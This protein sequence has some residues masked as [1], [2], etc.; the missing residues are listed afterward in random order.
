[1]T[2]LFLFFFL[3]HFFVVRALVDWEKFHNSYLLY[4]YSFKNEIKLIKNFLI[5]LKTYLF[6]LILTGKT[7]H[8]IFM[9]HTF[10]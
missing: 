6:L 5:Y 10:F 7:T 9:C 3:L 8:K 2:L 4:L 1:M